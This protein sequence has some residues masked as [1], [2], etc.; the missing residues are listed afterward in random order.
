MMANDTA[1]LEGLDRYIEDLQALR[2]LLAAGDAERVLA[3]FERA[4]NARDQWIHTAE[5]S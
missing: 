4:K 5:A 1:V 3:H 2:E